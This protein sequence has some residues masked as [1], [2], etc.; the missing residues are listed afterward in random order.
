MTSRNGG[1]DSDDPQAG[2]ADIRDEVGSADPPP[3]TEAMITPR[4]VP[5]PPSTPPQGDGVICHVCGE[6]NQPGASYCL[7]CGVSLE[8][9]ETTEALPWVDEES[10]APDFDAAAGLLDLAEMDEV[11]PIRPEVDSGEPTDS[12]T[13][14]SSPRVTGR[15]ILAAV[16]TIAVVVLLFMTYRSVG[17]DDP[18]SAATAVTTGPTEL[19]SY[20]ASVSVLAGTVAEL[21]ADAAL[22]NADWESRSIEYQDALATL[23]GI[24]SRAAALPDLLSG[25][26]APDAIGTATHQRLVTSA[27]TIATAASEMVTGL[28]APDTGEARQAALRKFD[29]ATVE[30]ASLVGVVVQAAESLSSTTVG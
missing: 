17:A 15:Q 3:V 14:P 4:T 18:T 5:D 8:I 29:A 9:P 20:A 2:S 11:T 10:P 13:A 24:E 26:L 7:A 25:L 22:V 21:Q 6:Q 1:D 19:D 23:S 30:F 28:E 27:T 16:V 12:S